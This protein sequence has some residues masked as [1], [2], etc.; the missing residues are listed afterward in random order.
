MVSTYETISIFLN[1]QVKK[2]VSVD[3]IVIPMVQARISEDD[4]IWV[5]H[6]LSEM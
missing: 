6:C 4:K 5:F 1:Y 3:S 2:L